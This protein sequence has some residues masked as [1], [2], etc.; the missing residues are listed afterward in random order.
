MKI[1]LLVMAI[2]LL[3]LTASS[4]A[5]TLISPPVQNDGNTVSCTVFNVSTDPVEVT[6]TL[7]DGSGH[8]VVTNTGPIFPGV[9]SDFVA[10]FSNDTFYCKF[11][12][13][14]KRSSIR[15]YIRLF[16]NGNSVLVE[17]AR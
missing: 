4:D 17:E 13:S 12:F 3:V 14:G 6:V 11:T 2:A 16:V 1:H 10:G 8:P 15:G 7:F 9:S 5:V